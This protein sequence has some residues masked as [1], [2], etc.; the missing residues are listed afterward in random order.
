MHSSPWLALSF[1]LCVLPVVFTAGAMGQSLSSFTCTTP[2]PA[3][4]AATCT[5]T[6][7]ASAPRAGVSVAIKSP[8]T[9][10]GLSFPSSVLVSMYARSVKFNVL[11]TASTPKQNAVMSATVGSITRTAPLSVGATGTYSISSSSA[12]SPSPVIPGGSAVCS[13]S[14]NAAA[15][16]GGMVVSL[17]S[18][19]A[20]ILPVPASVTIPAGAQVVYFPTTASRQL[21]DETNVLNVI[22]T[23]KIPT[24]SQAITV[25]IDPRPLFELKG[26]EAE[27]K[28]FDVE[29]DT[30]GA[31]VYASTAP[32]TWVGTLNVR[33]AGDV[34]FSTVTS[35]NG[36]ANGLAFKQGGAQNTNTAFVDF[37]G[38]GFA[39]VFDAEGELNFALKSVHSFAQRKALP[40]SAIRFA[41]DV[42]DATLSRFHFMSYVVSGRLAFT[43]SARGV[44]GVYTV[45]AGQED[46]LFGAGKVIRVR[47][48]WTSAGAKL[49]INDNLVAQTAGVPIVFNWS[50]LSS[51]TIGSA[52]GGAYASDDAIADF[53]IR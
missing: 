20:T 32:S 14:L 3:G 49:Y 43:Y 27:V 48:T 13:I 34:A 45:P 18:S 41:F 50:S 24:D 25:P 46:V 31:R 52:R 37:S 22:L 11:T 5:V 9:L 21:P 15:P 38:S 16:V 7:S 17:T 4:S 29:N 8:T 47:T 36:L 26:N 42:S 2:V 30:D 51:V 23:A 10:G 12:C 28:R 6:L 40:S 44:T 19:A 33:N 53:K 35:A 39:N 1:R